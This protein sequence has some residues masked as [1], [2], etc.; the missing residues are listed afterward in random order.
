MKGSPAELAEHLWA[1]AA[2]DSA[3]PEDV[4]AAV[5]C[6]CSELAS[7]LGR[8]IGAD[9]FRALVQRA[10]VIARAQHPVLD[11]FSC[12]GGSR[13]LENTEAAP[14]ELHRAAEV[15][16]GMVALLSALIELLGR[17]IGDEMAL[18]LVA[19]IEMPSSRAVAKVGSEE[20]RNG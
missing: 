15:A 1:C 19:K 6:L 17:I 9:G 8:W 11:G 5:E 20:D 12:L 2:H 16:A 13:Q 14:P 18:H 10:R 3:A 4:N 7:E